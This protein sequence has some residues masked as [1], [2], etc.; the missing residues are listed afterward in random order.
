MVNTQ[1]S[2][3]ADG[4]KVCV[5]VYP[6]GQPLPTPGLSKLRA[7]HRDKHISASSCQRTRSAR[8]RLGDRCAHS[9]EQEGGGSSSPSLRAERVLVGKWRQATARPSLGPNSGRDTG[10]HRLAYL[11]APR[12]APRA[13]VTEYA[14]W[15]GIPTD[16]LTCLS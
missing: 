1:A 11:D 9:F 16:D 7:D 10:R 3:F 12:A 4:D 8:A 5:C 2:L 6:Q 14:H 15:R 13:A